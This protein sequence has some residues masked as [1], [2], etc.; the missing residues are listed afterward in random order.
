VDGWTAIKADM[1][2]FSHPRNRGTSTKST[3]KTKQQ[4]RPT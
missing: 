1:K 3:E 4:S 2:S